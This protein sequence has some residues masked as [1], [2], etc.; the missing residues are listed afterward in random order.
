M[1]AVP[2]VL[3]ESQG[4]LSIEAQLRDVPI[5]AKVVSARDRHKLFKHKFSKPVAVYEDWLRTQTGDL[6]APWPR[7][8]LNYYSALLRANATCLEAWQVLSREALLGVVDGVR[9]GLLEFALEL[10]REAPI[11]E[12]GVLSEFA[13][14][15]ERITQ[16]FA[17]T[18]YAGVNIEQPINVQGSTIG[19]LAGGRDNLVRQGDVSLTQQGVK[20]DA[21]LGALRAAVEQLPGERRDATRGLVEDLEEDVASPQPAQHRLLRKLKGIAVIAGAAGS[22]GTAV[23]DAV[24]AIQRALDS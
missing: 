24:R 20:L 13:I 1:N 10:E 14:T 3:S 17:T 15:Q 5:A 12:N 11:A 23:I 22:A 19:N 18:I 6:R 4:E 7:D 21:L 8:A 16:V 2:E 9:N